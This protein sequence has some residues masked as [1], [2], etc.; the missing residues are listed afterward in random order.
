ML[1]NRDESESEDHK[2]A[3]SF[4]MRYEKDLRTRLR[5]FPRDAKTWYFLGCH[6]RMDRRYNEAEA[7]LRKAISINNTPGHFWSE[8][9]LV[10]QDI[11]QHDEAAKVKA[12][13]KA[14]SNKERSLD[15]VESSLNETRLGNE[16]KS[17][18]PEPTDERGMSPC[19]GCSAH[20]Y[21][22]CNQGEP[23]GKL[24]AYRSG[25]SK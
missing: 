9:V 16:L 14:K 13:M 1:E 17:P 8:L 15:S 11:G 23:C 12:R 25:A 2:S 4:S 22:G 21:Y 18:S 24:I 20:T 3:Q 7:A 6:L 5:A 19:I 10:L